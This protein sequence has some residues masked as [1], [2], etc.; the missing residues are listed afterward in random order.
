[1]NSLK[2]PRPVMNSSCLLGNPNTQEIATDN[3]QLL[4]YF[5]GEPSVD[6]VQEPVRHTSWSRELLSQGIS[7]PLDEDLPR[8]MQSNWHSLPSDSREEAELPKAVAVDGSTARRFLALGSMFYVV[9]SL[10]L[11]GKRRARRLESDV[12]AWSLRARSREGS[13]RVHH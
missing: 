12:F 5:G 4:Q 6:R 10:A 9:R 7:N 11:C 13:K 8:P 2:T 3:C 1:L